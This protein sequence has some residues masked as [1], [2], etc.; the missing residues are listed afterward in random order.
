MSSEHTLDNRRG[1]I[2][3]QLSTAS[4]FSGGKRRRSSEISQKRKLSLL[5]PNAKDKTLLKKKKKRKSI[6]SIVR[7][8]NSLQHDSFKPKELPQ[9]NG[10][11]EDLVDLFTVPVAKLHIND[12]KGLLS[13]DKSIDRLINLTLIVSLVLAGIASASL[14]Q[15]VIHFGFGP[16]TRILPKD[17]TFSNDKTYLNLINTISF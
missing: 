13:K 2:L 17:G 11:V 4:I 5:V 7:T 9:E 6:I 16:T 10:W 15:L 1:S 8:K 12:D 14:A 3:S